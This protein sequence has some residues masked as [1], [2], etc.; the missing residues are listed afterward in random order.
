MADQSAK[1]FVINLQEYELSDNNCLAIGETTHSE[2]GFS[3]VKKSLCTKIS[4]TLS[5]LIPFNKN[6]FEIKPTKSHID[7]ILRNLEIFSTVS[8]G[9][10]TMPI[11]I[12]NEAITSRLEFETGIMQL[13]WWP[14]Y[15]QSIGINQKFGVNDPT[16]YSLVVWN[17]TDK[18]I[19]QLLKFADMFDTRMQQLCSSEKIEFFTN[20]SVETKKIF[21]YCLLRDDF[22]ILDDELIGSNYVVPKQFIVLKLWIEKSSDKKNPRVLTKFFKDGVCLPIFSGSDLKNLENLIKFNSKIK[23]TIHFDDL[24]VKCTDNMCNIFPRCYLTS[25]TICD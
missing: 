4:H 12:K 1:N 11:T 18:N 24:F 3:H 25:L 5:N 2:K 15:Y 6:N 17:N 13:G 20:P 21:Y 19:K 22:I 23:I 7:K 9:C 14:W 10:D 8:A 16:K